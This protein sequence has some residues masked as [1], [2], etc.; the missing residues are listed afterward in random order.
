MRTIIIIALS[1]LS[2]E[3]VRS[4]VEDTAPPKAENLELLAKP[5]VTQA[6]KVKQKP[7]TVN[8]KSNRENASVQRKVIQTPVKSKQVSLKKT[9]AVA[10]KIESQNVKIGQ[11]TGREHMIVVDEKSDKFKKV[12]ALIARGYSNRKI[13]R[14]AKVRSP[15]IY[16]VRTYLEDE[17]K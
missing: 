1:I 8:A 3:K 14:K 2:Y 10:S 15:Y 11:V 9:K 4:I 17:T 5:K 7:R 16:A 13:R 12:K 6:K